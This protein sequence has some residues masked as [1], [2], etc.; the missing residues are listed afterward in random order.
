MKLYF[1]RHGDAVHMAGRDSE[2]PLSQT[3][4]EETQSVARLLKKMNVQLD[5]L[6]TS[7]RVRAQQTAEILSESLGVPVTTS[8]ACDFSFSADAVDDL[9]DRLDDD[10]GAVMFVG[11]NPS[12]SEVVGELTG[13][14]VQMKTAA[15]A[16]VDIDGVLDWLITPKIAS[17]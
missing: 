11:H 2:R 15:V 12:M 5:A 14:Y 9:I 17:A 7:P 3:G 6:Y 13:A 16:R 1:V 8:R 10:A 4:I